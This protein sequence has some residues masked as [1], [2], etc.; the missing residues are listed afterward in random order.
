MENRDVCSCS[1]CDYLLGA[2][3][4]VSEVCFGGFCVGNDFDDDGEAAVEGKVCVLVRFCPVV[5][6]C[7]EQFECDRCV[8]WYGF[9]VVLEM[10]EIKVVGFFV[11]VFRWKGVMAVVG[12]HGDSCV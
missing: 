3:G 11:A 4:S 5:G 7:D 9:V 8:Q 1:C 10:V 2:I 6:G 12:V